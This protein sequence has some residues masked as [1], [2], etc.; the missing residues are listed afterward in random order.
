MAKMKDGH[1]DG[2]TVISHVMPLEQI[3]QALLLRD[4]RAG[5]LK[6]VI[7]P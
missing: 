5:A 1:V 7:T 3:E 2:Q 6:I 4:D